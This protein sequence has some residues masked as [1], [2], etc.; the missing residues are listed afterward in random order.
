M[1]DILVS[2]HRLQH[3]SEVQANGLLAVMPTDTLQRLLPDMEKVRLVG[4]E[5]LYDAGAELRHAYF[6]ID[7]IV[8]LLLHTGQGST[9]QVA[10]IGHEGLAGVSVFLGGI[11][12]SSA[13]VLNTGYAF[14]IP[15]ATLKA[16]FDRNGATM[17]LLLRFTQAVVTQMAQTSVCNRHHQLEH[18]LCSWLLVC[19]D[20]LPYGR[21]LKVTQETVAGMLGVRREGVTEATGKLRQ[22]GLIGGSRGEIRLLSRGGL[23]ARACE[24][25]Q[26]V[27]NETRRLLPDRPAT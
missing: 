26:V 22:L 17:R 19:M 18:Q 6:P 15:A 20:R 4:G 7:A 8:A 2:P 14:K 21:S 10:A 5:V 25:Y 11:A 1:Q 3:R 12:H 23:Q 13:K 9:T 24:C 27:K 16:E